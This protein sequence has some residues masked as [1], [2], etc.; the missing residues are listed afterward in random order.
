MGKKRW[1]IVGFLLMA[2][3]GRAGEPVFAEP[4]E[5]SVESIAQAC[6]TPRDLAR[7]LQKRMTFQTDSQLFGK[8]DH[9]QSPEEFLKRGSGDCEDYALLAQAVFA[10]QGREA[11]VLS[12]FGR[13]GYAHTVCVFSERGRWRVLTQDRLLPVRAPSLEEAAS[14][15]H[16]QWT[17]GGISERVGFRGRLVREIQNPAPAPLTGFTSSDLENLPFY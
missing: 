13:D 10:S 2:S 15:L 11:Y 14:T 12:L 7:F 6:P 8:E 9:W 3:V 16:P 17:W 1:R 5:L 4:P